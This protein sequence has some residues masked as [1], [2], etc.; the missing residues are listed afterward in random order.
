MTK[1]YD[2]GGTKL[3]RPFRIQRFGHI[4]LTSKNNK[5]THEFWCDNLGFRAADSLQPPGAP[6]AFGYFSS[7]G[8][9]HHSLVNIEAMLLAEDPAYKKGVTVN[10]I[11]FQVGTLEEVSKGNQYFN[12]LG[13]GCWRYGRDYPGSN[14]ANYTYDPDGFQVELFYG[15]EQ[16]G[17]DRRSKPAEFHRDT[18]YQPQGAE[19][20]EMSEIL[21]AEAQQDE[22]PL[23]FRPEE[24]MPYDYVVGGVKLQ[25][26]FAI[27]KMGPVYIFVEDIDKSHEF[28]EQHVGLVVTEEVEWRGHKAVFL[29]CNSNHHV[30]GLFSLGIRKELGLSE[31][32]RLFSFGVELGS[33]K[34][35][36]DAV[37][38]LRDRD[39]TVRTDLP[40]EL[41]PG[42]GYSAL[43]TDANGHSA[44]IYSGM[45]QIGWDGKPRPAESRER[46]SAEWPETIETE[47]DTFMSLGRQGPM[48]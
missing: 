10:Q 8:T 39:V 36:R 43:V 16:I 18:S 40:Q 42:I 37:S 7:V 22:I 19:F 25:R 1:S 26:P 6:A 17:W 15:M 31:E 35:L 33:Y 47:L 41:H 5:E 23:G 28:Y 29:R 30:M 3:P 2:V 44:L 11:S 14:W 32:T 13:A 12:E 20:P 46:L 48:C 38:W 45:E 27:D 4:G 24:N 34:Q 9:E 21:E